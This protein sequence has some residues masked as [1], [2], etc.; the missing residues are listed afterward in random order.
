MGPPS[1]PVMG[2]PEGPPSPVGRVF[3]WTSYPT[4]GRASDDG[5]PSPRPPTRWAFA[6]GAAPPPARPL[7]APPRHLGRPRSR[8]NPGHARQ[9]VTMP[10]SRQPSR[11]RSPPIQHVRPQLRPIV[12][13]VARTLGIGHRQG[14]PSV[15]ARTR[16]TA[17]KLVGD[18]SGAMISGALETAARSSASRADR[19]RW[20]SFRLLM[21]SVSIGPPHARREMAGFWDGR[22]PGRTAS[23]GQL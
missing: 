6:R 14:R 20:P 4:T 2:P 12:G 8:P 21:S 9:P 13:I 17:T 5:R 18:Q 15:L 23:G 1:L 3:G 16:F 10:T 7:P 19:P 11:P 22:D